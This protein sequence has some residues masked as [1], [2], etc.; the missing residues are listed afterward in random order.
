M[1]IGQPF[2][3]FSN[4]PNELGEKGEENLMN[5][6]AEEDEDEN[7]MRPEINGEYEQELLDNNLEFKFEKMRLTKSNKISENAELLYLFK[8][9]KEKDPNLDN[10]ILEFKKQ[11]NVYKKIAQGKKDFICRIYFLNISNTMLD[12]TKNQLGFISIKRFPRDE[13]FISD[14]K[15]FDIEHGEINDVVCLNLKWPVYLPI[16]R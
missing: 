2:E 11:V 1:R 4:S 15:K 9:I 16:G 8:L 7:L 3:I 5:N 6:N 12:Q 10:E 13:N 14:Y